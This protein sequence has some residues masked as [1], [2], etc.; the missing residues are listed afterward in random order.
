MPSRLSFE[1]VKEVIESNID[2][3]LISTEYVY[4][5]K[6]IEIKHLKCGHIYR[7]TYSNFRSGSGRCPVCFTDKFTLQHCAN[8]ANDL[9]FY[10][11]S[12]EYISARKKL[13]F[14]HIVCGTIFYSTWDAFSRSGKRSQCPSCSKRMNKEYNKRRVT[15]IAKNG[16]LFDS[17][18]NLIKEWSSKNEKSPREYP[19]SCAE[20]VWWKCPKGH[21]DY[22]SSIG[23]RTGQ[24]CGCPECSHS[25][26]YTIVEV[27]KF[28]EDDRHILISKKYENCKEKLKVKCPNCK[29]VFL[30]SFDNFRRGKRCPHCSI[31]KGAERVEKFLLSLGL[32]KRKDFYREFIFEDCFYIKPLRFDFYIKKY[33]FVCEYQGEQHYSPVQFGGEGE[34]KGL[35]TFNQNKIRDGIKVKYCKSKRIPLLIIPYWEKENI[36]NIIL[37]FIKKNNLALD[38]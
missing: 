38:K 24:N 16:S 10:I 34:E 31:S 36:E 28:V 8:I 19:S 6:P 4:S 20:K 33:G 32:S 25:K 9:G 3:K 12:K 37:D 7:T 15:Y 27:R 1:H 2:Y 30:I 23:L 35:H 29:D 21:E 22:L 26:K 13:E 17:F 18:P 14:E 11:L 5:Q